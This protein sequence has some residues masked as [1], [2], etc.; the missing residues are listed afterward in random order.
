MHVDL[1]NIRRLNVYIL[2]FFR[3]NILSLC[4]FK[5]ILGS[6]NDSD[7]TIG[8]DDADIPRHEPPVTHRL[9]ILLLVLEVSLEDRWT[10]KTDL[11]SR[12][13]TIMGR[14]PH[15][16]DVSQT[17]LATG[18]W[19]PDMASYRI[20]RKC[21]TGCSCRLRLPVAFDYRATEADFEE[22]EHF[23]GYWGGTCGH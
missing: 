6:V 13:G 22:V 9:S 3:R 2:Q 15:L 19:T 18:D 1:L 10:L 12:V 7:A 11:T 4:Q 23:N 20:M 21:C 16:G 8:Q 5:D 17:D 14:V